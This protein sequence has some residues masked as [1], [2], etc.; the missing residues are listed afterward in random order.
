MWRPSSS[1]DSGR[2]LRR[3]NGVRL[4]A[5][6]VPTPRTKRPPVMWSRVRAVWASDAGWRRTMSV[7]P[8]P[9]RT[10][11][12]A[13]AAAATTGTGSNHTCGLAWPAAACGTSSGVQIDS[14]NQ[15]RKWSAHHTASN[16]CRSRRWAAATAASAGGRTAPMA[17]SS[18]GLRSA[19]A[20]NLPPQPRL[21]NLRRPAASCRSRRSRPGFRTSAG[22][23]LPARAA[24]V[25]TA[26]RSAGRRATRRRATAPPGRRRA[27]P[28][29]RPPGLRRPRRPHPGRRDAQ[30][31]RQRSGVGLV[32][33]LGRQRRAQRRRP[34]AA[35]AHPCRPDRPAAG[36]R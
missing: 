4:S 3:P 10:S 33:R 23:G 15:W 13:P 6:P 18:R 20:A 29:P 14:G 36:R 19:M 2:R 32:R 11:R 5:S 7:T 8:M 1:R 26:R 16:P 28:A 25:A 24:A 22:T 35:P 21:A 17:D 9:R 34:R 12:V 30:H 31:A 27:A